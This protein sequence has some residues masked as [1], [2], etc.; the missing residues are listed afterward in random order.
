MQFSRVVPYKFMWKAKIPL[1]VKTFLWLVLKDSI[2]TRDVLSHRGGVCEKKCLF[3]GKNQTIS[4]LFFHCPLARY[5][6]NIISCTFG[7]N[8]QFASIDQCIN[9]WLKGL[10]KKKRNLFAIG[11]SAV[12]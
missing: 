1:K 2:L 4:H 10:G 9:V 5:I 12:V 3:C 6:W 7:F 11:I 8:F